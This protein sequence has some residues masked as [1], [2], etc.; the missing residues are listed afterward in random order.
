MTE[1]PPREG[2]DIVDAWQPTRDD[3]T[4]KREI[5]ASPERVWQL[6]EKFERGI[7][8]AGRQF[9]LVTAVRII[10]F[11]PRWLIDNR[12]IDILETYAF[13]RSAPHQAFPGLLGDQPAIWVEARTAIE[14]YISRA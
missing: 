9:D 7:A 11:E 14:D 12:T 3:G 5:T 13:Y 6:V 4:P 8:E 1:E 2:V 10:G